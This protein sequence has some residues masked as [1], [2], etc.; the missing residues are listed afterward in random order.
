M[1]RY[2]YKLNL[3]KR[4]EDNHIPP[5]ASIDEMLEIIKFNHGNLPSAEYGQIMNLLTIQDVKIHDIMLP[6]NRVAFINGDDLLTPKLVDELHKTHNGFAL[7][8]KD[9]LKNIIGSLSLGGPD[10]LEQIKTPTKISDK[11]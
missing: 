9:D 10:L 3:A 6:K 1:S 7:V 2:F 4:D 5:V 11:I 8:F